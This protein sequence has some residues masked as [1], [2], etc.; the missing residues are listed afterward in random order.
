MKGLVKFAKGEEGVEI[1]EIPVPI[2]SE[3]ELKVKVLAA[4]I[5][6]SDIHAVRDEGNRAVNMPVIL[7]HEYVGQVVETCGDTG[8]FKAGDWVTTLPACYS[9]GDCEFCRAGLVTL[10]KNRKSIGTHV[11]GAMAQYVKVPAKYSFKLP[12]SAKTMEEKK[13]YALAEPMC[14]VVRGIYE[15]ITVKPGDL[16]VVSGPGPMG[17]L[18]VQLF[19]ER[20]AYVV[21]SGLPMDRERLNLALQLGADEAVESFEALQAAVYGRNP[22]GADVTCDTTGVAPALANCFEI[23]KTHGVHLQVGIFG[24]PIQINIDRLF[25]KEVNY[26]ATNSTAMSSWKIGMALLDQ[27]KVDLTPLMNMEVSLDNW[28]EGFDRAI[29]KTKLKVVLLPDNDF[30]V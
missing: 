2:L 7:G 13:I 3:G 6:G 29:D 28:R 24:K 20:G 25:D 27:K 11:N 22:A 1:R 9:C 30:E 5:C 10:C 14:C 15:R 12:E 18:A 19:K 4:G 8:E 16:A 23:V 21:V 17:L 26:V